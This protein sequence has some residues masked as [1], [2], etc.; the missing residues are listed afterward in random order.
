[1]PDV[2]LAQHPR[3]PPRQGRCKHRPNAVRNA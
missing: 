2:L 1:L 3:V